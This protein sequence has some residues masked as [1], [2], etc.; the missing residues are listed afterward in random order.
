MPGSSL[1]ARKSGGGSGFSSDSSASVLKETSMR[2]KYGSIPLS[3]T[4]NPS[5]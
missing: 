1:S 5:M 4:A 3:F 2:S